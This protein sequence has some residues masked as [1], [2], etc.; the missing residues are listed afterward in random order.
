MDN[1]PIYHGL[2]IHMLYDAWNANFEG[3]YRCYAPSNFPYNIPDK[4]MYGRIIEFSNS[5]PLDIYYLCID[6]DKRL[7]IGIKLY[8]KINIEWGMH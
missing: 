7:Y 5:N 4:V 1:I 8:G 3:I 6:A 2:N